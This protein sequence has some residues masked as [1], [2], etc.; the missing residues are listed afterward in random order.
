LKKLTGP[1][2]FYKLETEPNPNKKKIK[3]NRKNRTETG[4]FKPVLVFIF[5]KKIRFNYFFFLIK[6]ESN[7]KWYIWKNIYP[8]SELISEKVLCQQWFWY[9]CLPTFSL[10]LVDHKNSWMSA[11]HAF[12]LYLSENIN[13]KSE[14]VHVC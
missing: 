9:K 12:N 3:L 13:Y 6:T 7:K 1:V 8:S 4:Q 14:M 2:W 11:F 10:C 5:L